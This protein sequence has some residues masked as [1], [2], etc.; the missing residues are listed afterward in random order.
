MSHFQC[1]QAH[2]N[3][4]YYAVLEENRGNCQESIVSVV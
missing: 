1:K 3:S 4:D 2:T